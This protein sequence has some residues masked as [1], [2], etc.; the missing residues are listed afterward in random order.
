M[1]R[2]TTERI[3]RRP[4]LQSPALSEVLGSKRLDGTCTTICTPL[5]RRRCPLLDRLDWKSDIRPQ[6]KETGLT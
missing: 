2:N 5:T 1:D 6:H 4:P 3:A